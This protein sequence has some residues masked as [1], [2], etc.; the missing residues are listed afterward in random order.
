MNKRPATTRSAMRGWTLA[1]CSAALAVAAHGMAGGGAPDTAL[2]VLLTMLV[3]WAGTS[4]ANRLRGA[5]AVLTALGTA[6]GAMHLILNYVVPSHVGHTA[7]PVS[8]SVMF[9]THAVA[10]VIAGLLITKAD[11]AIGLVSSAMRMLLDLIRPPRF[12][13]VPVAI[14]ALPTSHLPADH[15]RQVLLR[16]VHARRGPPACS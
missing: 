1:V 5:F 9:L 3:A 4:V 2:A 8:P 15:I 11:A 13:V 10:T 14:Y 12:P 6:Q 7:A 16:R